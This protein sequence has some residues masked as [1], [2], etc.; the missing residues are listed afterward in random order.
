MSTAVS[1]AAPLPELVAALAAQGFAP[2][3]P[4]KLS[5]TSRAADKYVCRRLRCPSCRKRGLA[6][7]PFVNAS[8]QYRVVASCPE[9][10]AAEE[11]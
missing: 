10:H 8:G 3:F 6:Y 4:G 5:L 7:R 2:G 9:C 1:P 11:V